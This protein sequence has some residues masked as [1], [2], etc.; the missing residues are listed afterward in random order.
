[1]QTLS[2]TLPVILKKS[3]VK[4]KKLLSLFWVFLIATA[5]SLSVFYV[6]QIN[7]EISEKYAALNYEKELVELMR[8]KESLEMGVESS[9][10]LDNVLLLL[11][12]S[13]MGFVEAEK[14]NHLKIS[15]DRIVSR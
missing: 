10:S 12:S 3:A 8:K 1:M 4:K 5:F 2:L 11:D 6:F 7:T 14:V 9:A 13:D 15:N